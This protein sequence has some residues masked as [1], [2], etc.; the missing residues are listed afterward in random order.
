[1]ESAGSKRLRTGSGLDIIPN[2]GGGNAVS[3]RKRRRNRFAEPQE[4]AQAP[5]PSAADEVRLVGYLAAGIL[6]EW[7]G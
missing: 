2:G 7:M 1:M 4:D 3:E 5:A 6:L